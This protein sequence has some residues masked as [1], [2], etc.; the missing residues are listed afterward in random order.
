MNIV[1]V[2]VHP[3]K[4]DRIPRDHDGV[5]N[6]NNDITFSDRTEREEQSLLLVSDY[7][8]LARE[9][10]KIAKDHGVKDDIINALLDRKTMNHGMEIKPRK[11]SDIMLGQYEIGKVIRINRKNDEYTISNKIFDFSY[12]NYQ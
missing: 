1:I 12:Q 5:I 10:I 11:Y 9:L 3:L 4:Q 2:N 8:D 7:V 6:R